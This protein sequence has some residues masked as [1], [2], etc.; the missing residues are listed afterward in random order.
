[1]MGESSR[2]SVLLGVSDYFAT[3]VRPGTSY[4]FGNGT[5]YATPL[6]AGAAALVVQAHPTWTPAQMRTALMTTA[7][8]ALTP[9]NTYGNG[10][11]NAL[12]AINDSAA[13]VG[14]WMLYE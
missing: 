4:Y 1:M 13:S 6:I 8:R 14:D 7:S 10:I 12:A 9:D 2:R 11:I 3:N 5:S